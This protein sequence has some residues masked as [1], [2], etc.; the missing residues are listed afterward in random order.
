[1]KRTTE[2]FIGM[3]SLFRLYD[4]LLKKV[5]MEHDLTMIE[6]DIISFLQNNPGKDT[7]ADI[8]ELRLLSKGAV[9]K[10]VE[11]LIQKSLLE[12]IPDTED[13]RKIHLR[14]KPQAGPVTETVNEVRDE[15]LETVLAGFTKEELEMQSRFLRKLFD[16][17]KKHEDIIKTIRY[18]FDKNS[19][20]TNI[21]NA[22]VFISGFN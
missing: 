22:Y 5:C 20:S 8:V 21:A 14:L 1:M 19:K 12:R 11:S 7:A 16:Y 18:G 15:F 2:I 3:R 6:A 10:G 17:K 13:R 9:S 4:K